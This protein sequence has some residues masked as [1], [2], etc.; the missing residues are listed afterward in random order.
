MMSDIKAGKHIHKQR[1][2]YLFIVFL[3]T[4]LVIH[5]ALSNPLGSFASAQ[6]EQPSSVAPGTTTAAATPDFTLSASPNSL[7]VAQRLRYHYHF[8]HRKW[9]LQRC[10]FIVGVR[11]AFRSNRKL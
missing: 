2:F 1:W 6:K 10:G 5:F 7:S 9:R 4:V 11:L 8:K 3:P